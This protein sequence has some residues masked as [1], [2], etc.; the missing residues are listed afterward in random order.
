[1]KIHLTGNDRERLSVDDA[2]DQ[3]LDESEESFGGVESMWVYISGPHA[4]ITAGEEAC[5][6]RK[7][8]GI[9]WYGAK[10]DV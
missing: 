2:L 8:R 6:K 5:K 9:D 10:W 1:M 4:F 3:I 7:G